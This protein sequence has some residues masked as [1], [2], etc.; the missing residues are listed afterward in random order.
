MRDIKGSTI[1]AC[2][3]MFPRSVVV[4]MLIL[5]FCFSAVWAEPWTDYV[6]EQADPELISL[7]QRAHAAETVSDIGRLVEESDP[8]DLV[9]W[10]RELLTGLARASLEA[11]TWVIPGRLELL[12]KTVQLAALLRE[13][14]RQSGRLESLYEPI[15]DE[16][17]ALSALIGVPAKTF[18]IRVLWGSPISLHDDTS[19]AV[20]DSQYRFVRDTL[21]PVKHLCDA[22]ICHSLVGRAIHGLGPDYTPVDEAWIKASGYIPS[23]TVGSALTMPIAGYFSLL[24]MGKMAILGSAFSSEEKL[25]LKVALLGGLEA[26]GWFGMEWTS[27]ISYVYFH[28]RDF[29]RSSLSAGGLRQS[30][31]ARVLRA[32]ANSV[33]FARGYEQAESDYASLLNH[34]LL[35]KKHSRVVRWRQL[36]SGLSAATRGRPRVIDFKGI[37]DDSPAGSLDRAAFNVIAMHEAAASALADDTSSTVVWPSD[38]QLGRLRRALD[39]LPTTEQGRT[40]YEDW[41]RAFNRDMHTIARPDVALRF[42]A[43]QID[44]VDRRFPRRGATRLRQHLTREFLA[45][46]REISYLISFRIRDGVWVLRDGVSPDGSEFIEVVEVLRHPELFDLGERL[47]ASTSPE[48][49]RSSSLQNYGVTLLHRDCLAQSSAGE[50]AG[51]LCRQEQPL[52]LPPTW[53]DMVQWA[54]GAMHQSPPNYRPYMKVVWA[55]WLGIPSGIFQR[56]GFSGWRYRVLDSLELTERGLAERILERTSDNERRILETMIFARTFLERQR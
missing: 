14:E 35:T 13:E 18:G 2:G 19:P 20:R 28:G 23:D 16:A 21:N 31:I 10:R 9:S 8:T 55:S 4:S 40:D 12:V 43:A 15:R 44:R 17:E 32:R 46:A 11:D 50:K 49:D 41:L 6:D 3:V 26:L 45:Y 24:A 7:L 33:F 36:L 1:M 29:T 30:D 53:R 42:L 47:Y 39:G 37:I 56:R 38:E 34:E 27:Q 25:P 5:W 54:K 51:Q 48:E 52:N 22:Q